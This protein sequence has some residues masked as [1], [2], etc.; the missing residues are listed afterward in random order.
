MF[1]QV[2]RRY[3]SAILMRGLVKGKKEM[4]KPEGSLICT[5]RR[6]GLDPMPRTP[7]DVRTVQ[8]FEVW[9]ERGRVYR[10]ST[11]R[12]QWVR[13]CTLS[14]VRGREVLGRNITVCTYGDIA[15]GAQQPYFAGLQDCKAGQYSALAHSLFTAQLKEGD[16]VI[17][18][19]PLP[20]DIFDLIQ[21]E[22][23]AFR[24]HMLDTNGV[25]VPGARKPAA[26]ATQRS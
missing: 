21:S 23:Y 17:V 12:P 3:V 7:G 24:L 25:S 1:V 26:V 2:A 8:L 4:A 18:R 16:A 5:V 20:P 6:F 9:D 13:G 14:I 11:L 15:G 19:G 10:F 22:C